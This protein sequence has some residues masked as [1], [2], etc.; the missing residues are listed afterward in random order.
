MKTV[1][2]WIICNIMYIIQT[3]RLLDDNLLTSVRK[4]WQFI[5]TNSERSPL[6]YLLV[7]NCCS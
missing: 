1:F 2:N 4:G 6:E 3:N 5:V 7:F